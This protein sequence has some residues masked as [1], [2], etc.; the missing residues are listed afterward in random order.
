MPPAFSAL[1]KP[2][3]FSVSSDTAVSARLAVQDHCVVFT[4]TSFRNL[5]SDVGV[6]DV[7]CT[8]DV[9]GGVFLRSAHVD[10][11]LFGP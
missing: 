3:D 4:H 9:V 7:D 11:Y 1:L 6:L 10:H 5:F 2:K 8:R